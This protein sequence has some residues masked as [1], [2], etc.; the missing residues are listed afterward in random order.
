LC[1]LIGNDDANVQSESS[2]IVNTWAD[3]GQ[4]DALCQRLRKSA[5]T[6]SN[7]NRPRQQLI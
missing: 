4:F 5:A 3:R 7:R 2:R 6:A 1:Q